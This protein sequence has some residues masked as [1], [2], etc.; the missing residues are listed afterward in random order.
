[1]NNVLERA[2]KTFVESAL[3]YLT[4]A[5]VG[6][7]F[8]GDNL[9]RVLIGIGISCVAAGISAVWNGVVDPLLKEQTEQPVESLAD[10][11]FRG[12]DE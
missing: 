7:D 2:L 1:M 12:D 11:N 5:L 6:V 3:T 9:E 4:A 8:G 10:Y